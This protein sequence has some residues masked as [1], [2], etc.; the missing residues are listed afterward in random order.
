MADQI[1]LETRIQHISFSLSLS[2]SLK[3]VEGINIVMLSFCYCCQ[4]CC[5][6][7]CD[8]EVFLFHANSWKEK[9][10]RIKV[11]DSCSLLFLSFSLSLA[12]SFPFLTQHK[13]DGINKES[14]QSIKIRLTSFN[15][16]IFFSHSRLHLQRQQQSLNPPNS[17]TTTTLFLIDIM[18]DAKYFDEY[19]H[20]NFDSD[21]KIFSGHSGKQR[22]KKEVAENTNRFDPSGQTRK[23]VTKMQNTEENKKGTTRSRTSSSSS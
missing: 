6:V 7:C 12:V 13:E 22:S 4:A 15:S 9:P 16:T 17:T 23:L 19:D 5:L 2:L 8:I 14:N 10:M 18:A 11:R 1:E 3:V 20:Y 21:K